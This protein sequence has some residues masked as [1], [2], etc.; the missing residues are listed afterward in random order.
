MINRIEKF[1][2]VLRPYWFLLFMM[3]VISG[4]LYMVTTLIQSRSLLIDLLRFILASVG[5]TSYSLLVMVWFFF[6][7]GPVSS[8]WKNEE[9][10]EDLAV[11]KTSKDTKYARIVVGYILIIS[12][13]ISCLFLLYDYYIFLFINK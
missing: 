2:D 8:L 11:I 10:V 13:P 9:Q 7:P 12:L 5:L 4:M 3:P 6:G 1:T